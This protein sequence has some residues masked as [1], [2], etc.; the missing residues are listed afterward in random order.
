MDDKDFII[1]LFNL[2]DAENIDFQKT[3]ANI[4]GVNKAI[5]IYL[6]K[7]TDCCK[8]CS[9]SDIYI[10]GNKK[11]IVKH[12]LNGGYPCTVTIHKRVYKC[13]E[14]SS[15]FTESFNGFNESRG[16]SEALVFE[17]LHMLRDK[18]NNFYDTAKYFN[19]SNTFVE[20]VFDKYVDIKR[21][22]LPTVLSIDEIYSKGLSKTHYCCIL[23]DPINDLIIDCL[24]SRHKH[25]LSN[26]F[27][28]IDKEERSNVKYVAIDLYKTY[29]SI[30]NI[31][32][33]KALVCADS[34]HVIEN[35]QRA[36]DK[37]R[38]RVMKRYEEFKH[39][40]NFEYH[41]L[42]KYHWMLNKSIE[43]IE[44]RTYELS[45]NKM[46]LNKY[47]VIDYLLN[48]D[49]ELTEAYNLKEEYRNFNKTCKLDE[50]EN[51]LLELRDDFLKSNI[52]EMNEFGRLIHHWKTEIKNS[53]I[54][55]ENW[56]ISNANIERKN[57]DIGEIFFISRG[58][59]NFF[60]GRSKVMYSLNNDE[61]LL[62]TPKK[63][64]NKRKGKPRGGYKK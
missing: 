30:A 37:V 52:E 29:K 39:E 46:L 1:E 18:K 41:L 45:F 17:L 40:K 10:R 54:R 35:L 55:I 43:D 22:N 2:K 50:V 14:C 25:Y 15:T 47:Q 4:K 7:H 27:G 36:F 31:Y 11:Q 5:D 26:Y 56:R 61:P 3:K 38:I 9:S 28:M 53:F 24:N 44:N 33:P 19:V 32:F 63:V 59:T 34:F 51:K 62:A 6:E 12:V 16:I 49:L 21:H 48:I 13:L 42:K 20:Y 60:R 57:E 23:Y 64:S 58:L 8:N